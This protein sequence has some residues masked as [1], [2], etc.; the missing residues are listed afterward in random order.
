MGP[1]SSAPILHVPPSNARCGR[2]THRVRLTGPLGGHGSQLASSSAPGELSRMDTYRNQPRIIHEV[3]CPH[4]RA[5]NYEGL[6]GELTLALSRAS[7]P[8]FA[9]MALRSDGYSPA[10]FVPDGGRDG[11]PGSTGGRQRD[12]LAGNRGDRA[13]EARVLPTRR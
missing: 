9:A 2:Q 6:V 4:L 13:R 11:G 3:A 10:G 8:G 1:F 12:R 7:L 5:K